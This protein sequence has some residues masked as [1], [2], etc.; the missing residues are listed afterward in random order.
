M[1]YKAAAAT[2]VQPQHQY[3][4]ALLNNKLQTKKKKIKKERKN[5]Y[6][7]T[8]NNEKQQYT[9]EENSLISRR[10]A[11]FL[12]TKTTIANNWMATR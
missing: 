6:M 4:Q 9:R 10:N 5:K 3:M 7:R 1:N 11:A 12:Y 2:P 8:M